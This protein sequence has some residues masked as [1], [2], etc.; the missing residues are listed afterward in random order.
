[1]VVIAL[2]LTHFLQFMR[3]QSKN[4][5]EVFKPQAADDL[6]GKI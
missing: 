5:D 3:I 1:M 2:L 6:R 4:H